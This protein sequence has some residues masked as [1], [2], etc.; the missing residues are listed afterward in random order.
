MGRASRSPLALAI[1]LIAVAGWVDAIGFLRLGH[2]FV[3]FMS[4]NSTQ[5]VVLGVSGEWPDGAAAGAI[6]GLFVIGVIA[7][8]LLFNGARAWGRPVVLLAEAVSLAVGAT[9]GS[10][11]T[12]VIVPI[13]IAMGVQNAAIDKAHAA[14]MGLSYVT[15]TLVGLGDGV[16]DAIYSPRP[17][18]RWGWVPHLLH[19]LGLVLGAACG[20]VSYRSWGRTALLLPAM[21]AFLLAA[22]TAVAVSR[23]RA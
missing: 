21:L 11:T 5:L 13:V 16:A 22:V 9:A 19:W 2:L 3:S 18:S 4:G 6:V 7:G 10:S 12:A 15:G 8:R 23:R 1:A 20:A 17:V 14:D